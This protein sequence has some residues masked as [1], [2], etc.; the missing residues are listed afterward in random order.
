VGAPLPVLVVARAVVD[1]GVRCDAFARDK[2][3]RTGCVRDVAAELTGAE[4]S[5]SGVWGV[6]KLPV[7]ASFSTMTIIQTPTL[8]SEPSSGV[9]WIQRCCGV[10]GASERRREFEWLV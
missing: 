6:C 1:A 2:F 9:Q 3:V 8:A 10:G 4:A 7:M 5:G